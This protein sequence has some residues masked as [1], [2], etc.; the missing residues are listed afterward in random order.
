MNKDL[1]LWRRVYLSSVWV[2]TRRYVDVNTLSL[3]FS[4]SVCVSRGWYSWAVLW[5]PETPG[6][7]RRSWQHAVRRS[8]ATKFFALPLL[9]SQPHITQC[10][11]P[12]HEHDAYAC[13]TSS[14]ALSSLP[15][16]LW[17]FQSLFFFLPILLLVSLSVS[18]ELYVYV[19][20]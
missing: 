8:K 15:L 17:L 4:V 19:G 7:R 1:Y 12:Q 20:V 18:L 11:S 2:K 14:G 10:S 5:P 9:H 13:S 16:L 6:R 3:S